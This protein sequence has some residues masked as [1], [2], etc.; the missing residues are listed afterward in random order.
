MVSF[1][2]MML[3]FFVFEYYGQYGSCN[4]EGTFKKI[5]NQKS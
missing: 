3:I 4:L 5:V 1:Y 2:K